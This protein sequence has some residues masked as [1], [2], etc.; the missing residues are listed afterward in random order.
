MKGNAGV[1]VGTVLQ[2]V[3]AAWILVGPMKTEGM[4]PILD[5]VWTPESMSQVWSASLN[6][7]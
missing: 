6:C 1:D 5:L 3:L 4:D 7:W 2:L